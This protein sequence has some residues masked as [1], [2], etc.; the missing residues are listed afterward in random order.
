MSQRA[1]SWPWLS[2]LLIGGGAVALGVL[3]ALI[4]LRSLAG[5]TAMPVLLMLA[6]GWTWLIIPPAE[7]TWVIKVVLL[8]LLVR[9]GMSIALEYAWPGF[10]R[11]SDGASYGPHAQLIAQAWQKGQLARYSDVVS[12]PTSAFGYVYLNAL[13]YWTFGYNTLLIKLLNGLFAAMACGYVYLIGRR[14]LNQAS[15]RFAALS[16]ALMPSIILWTSQNLKDSLVMLLSVWVMWEV[17]EIS[18]HR[19]RH[20][21]GLG[22]LLLAL[23]SIRIETAL[24]L[25][26]ILGPSL[27]F[28][29]RGSVVNRLM[30]T[31]GGVFI[32]GWLLQQ[33]GYG[34]LGAEIVD[35]RLNIEA[36]AARQAGAS[37]GASAI[38]SVTPTSLPGFILYLP[39][40]VTNYLLRPWPWEV[41]S[42][43]QLATLPEAMLIWY[44]IFIMACWGIWKLIQRHALKTM[45]LWSYVV[46]ATLA[47]A[48]NYGNLGTA[49]RHRI[50]LWPFFFLLAGYGYSCAVRRNALPTNAQP[51]PVQQSASSHS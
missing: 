2:G 11:Q 36:I 17:L 49:Y 1:G 22:G 26:I 3:S 31:L 30:I 29:T 38:D 34:F 50:Q 10:E 28:Q 13:I 12:T 21:I 27:L 14:L 43:L 24:G 18:A 7:R 44:P 39:Q 8:A 37:Y 9:M 47:A 25:S 6:F 46:A 42:G 40:A 16:L 45:I 4:P 33:L 23:A 51:A 19:P 32:A 41:N 15:A 35:S 5:L 20:L 48:P